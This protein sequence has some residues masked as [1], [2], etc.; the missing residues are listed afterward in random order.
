MNGDACGVAMGLRA[1]ACI[2]A[3]SSA[4][5]SAVAEAK[6]MRGSGNERDRAPPHG[7]HAH[8][9]RSAKTAG[10]S[11]QKQDQARSARSTQRART[12]KQHAMGTE[13]GL[14]TLSRARSS[15]TALTGGSFPVWGAGASLQSSKYMTL[16]PCVG[17]RV[18]LYKNQLQCKYCTGF[19][20]ADWIPIE[21]NPGERTSWKKRGSRVST[22][23]SLCLCGGTRSPSSASRPCP[24]T[25]WTCRGAPS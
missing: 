22:Q 3:L 21:L 25:A 1:I 9:R 12:R 13:A 19:V 23:S 15:R 11:R 18:K 16:L 24:S 4:P 5:A 6:R 14:G 10:A 20:R 8:P 2:R 7:A 17:Q